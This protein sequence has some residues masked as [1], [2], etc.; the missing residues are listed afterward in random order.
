MPRSIK[1]GDVVLGSRER[2]TPA[3]VAVLASV[4]CVR[5]LVSRRVTVG[6]IATGDEIVE[7]GEEPSPSQIRNSNGP[8]LLAQAARMGAAPRYCGIA[9]DSEAAIDRVIAEAVAGND[10][11]ILSGGVSAG[12]LDLVPGVLR[13]NGFELLFEKIATKPGKPTIFG[14]SGEAFCIGLP[15]N[16]VSTLILFEVLVKPF[17]FKMMGHDF[18]PRRVS[19][20]LA[21]S[22]KRKKTGRMSWVPVAMT[23]AGGVLPVEYHGSAHIHSL[24]FADGLISIPVGV[25]EIKEGTSV[26][27]RQI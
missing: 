2:I 22:I 14:D 18:E 8:Q 3:H 15:G 6:I 21:K 7:P 11:I 12:D 13:R 5:P 23:A 19:M 25:P 16:P 10:V 20:P 9:R 26:H 1:A 4:G 27:V 24:C 17:L